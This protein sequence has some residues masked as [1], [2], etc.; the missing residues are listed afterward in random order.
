MTNRFTPTTV[1]SMLLHCHACGEFRP[2][3]QVFYPLGRNWVADQQCVDASGPR[4]WP[5][6]CQLLMDQIDQGPRVLAGSNR[7]CT[8]LAETHGH[9]ALRGN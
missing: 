3:S 5:A 2:G 9:Q 7:P 4:A 8:V 1:N 6:D